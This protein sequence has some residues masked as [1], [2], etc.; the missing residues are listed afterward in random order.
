MTFELGI[1]IAIA[2]MLVAF[3][4]V[5]ATYWWSEE[6]A[7]TSTKFIRAGGFL[8]IAASGLTI[9]ALVV[10]QQAGWLFIKWSAYAAVVFGVAGQI[11]M[12]RQMFRRLHRPHR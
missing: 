11:L 6:P 10:D 3:A 5:G 2:M 12:L 8:L 1:G 4:A 9:C 7:G